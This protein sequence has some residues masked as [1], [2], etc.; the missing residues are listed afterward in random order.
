MP[1]VIEDGTGLST[2]ESYLSVVDADTYIA[3]HGANA[4]WTAS[5]TA[6]KEEALRLATQ[7]LDL[8]YGIRFKGYRIDVDQSLC[9]PRYDVYDRDGYTVD[10]QSVPVQVKHATAEMALRYILGDDPL[11]VQTNPGEIKVERKK[12]GILEKEIEY[13]GGKPASGV[14]LYPRI[15]ALLLPLLESNTLV[16]R[17]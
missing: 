3:A 15:K 14:K 17:G 13:V 9:W 16:Q 12:L 8:Q 4:T 2:A 7:Y 1:L 6:D 10:Y 11:A 5:V